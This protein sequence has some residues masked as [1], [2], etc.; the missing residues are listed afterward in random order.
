MDNLLRL[1]LLNIGPRS[2]DFLGAKIRLYAFGRFVVGHLKGRIHL[3]EVKKALLLQGVY[4]TRLQV[5]GELESG[6]MELRHYALERK[7]LRPAKENPPLR[8]R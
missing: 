6:S 2:L 1:P 4:E 5:G 7:T 8:G 3:R